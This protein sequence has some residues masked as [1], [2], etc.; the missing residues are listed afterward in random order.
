V[1]LHA[2]RISEKIIAAGRLLLELIFVKDS[3]AEYA[4]GVSTLLLLLL[5]LL[6]FP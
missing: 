2:A 3:V 5:L 6:L 4:S 1:S